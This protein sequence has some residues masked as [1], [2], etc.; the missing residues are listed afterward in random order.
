MDENTKWVKIDSW[1]L[2]KETGLD[3]AG[4]PEVVTLCGLNRMWDGTFLD[5]LPGGEEK[6]CENCLI[7]K[8]GGKPKKASKKKA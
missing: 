2:I 4:I 5:R 7:I 3:R 1:H 8:V 6:S